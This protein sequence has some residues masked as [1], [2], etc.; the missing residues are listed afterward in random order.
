LISTTQQAFF[1]KFEFS[2]N[3]KSFSELL[4]SEGITYKRF[5][6]VAEAT[7]IISINIFACMANAI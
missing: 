1:E 7:I 5:K 2:L 3:T 6:R 4:L